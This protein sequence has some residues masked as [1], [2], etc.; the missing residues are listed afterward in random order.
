MEPPKQGKTPV[1]MRIPKLGQVVL[2]KDEKLPRR[3]W[4]LG[5]IMDVKVSNRDGKIREVTVQCLSKKAQNAEINSGPLPST[6]LKKI[7]LSFGAT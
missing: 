6:F 2:I 7:T 1:N 5:R 4:K 3:N